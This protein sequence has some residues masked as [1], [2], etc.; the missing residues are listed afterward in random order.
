[1]GSTELLGS[2]IRIEIEEEIRVVFRERRS[3]GLRRTRDWTTKRTGRH[4]PHG[5]RTPRLY[6]TPGF[7]RGT[8]SERKRPSQLPRPG[9]ASNSFNKT[10]KAEWA[11]VEII[12]KLNAGECRCDFAFLLGW[13]KCSAATMSRRTLPTCSTMTKK[14]LRRLMRMASDPGSRLQPFRL[15]NITR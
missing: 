6:A 15:A 4:R 7:R 11:S 5:F 12:G 1:M 8:F 13:F 9:D 2:D 3:L 14:S 10:M